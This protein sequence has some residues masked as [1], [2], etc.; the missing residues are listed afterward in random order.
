M[1][2]INGLWLGVRES[3]INSPFGVVQGLKTF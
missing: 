3:H 1:T 2:L